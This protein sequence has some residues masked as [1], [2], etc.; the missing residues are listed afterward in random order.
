MTFL[1]QCARNGFPTPYPPYVHDRQ[2]PPVKVLK[3]RF[4]N[5]APKGQ[6]HASPGHRPGNRIAC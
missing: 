5:L 2:T 1:H 6:R 4:L 3:L